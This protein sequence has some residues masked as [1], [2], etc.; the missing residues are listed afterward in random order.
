MHSNEC[1]LV[2]D[3]LL[4]VTS[5]STVLCLKFFGLGWAEGSTSSIA[6]AIWRQCTLMGGH[7]GA[8][9]TCR[10]LVNR[11]SAAAMRLYMSHYF[12]HLL[13]LVT[14]YYSTGSL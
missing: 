8:A 6:F 7:I 4:Q 5:N 1:R 13:C 3:F 10:I 14:S 12:D 11:L 9:Q 2:I